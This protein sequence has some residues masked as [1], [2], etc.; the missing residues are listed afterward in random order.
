MI[1]KVLS[2]ANGLHCGSP[3]TPLLRLAPRSLF[4]LYHIFEMLATP[5]FLC[6]AFL[7]LVSGAAVDY[8]GLSKRAIPTPVSASTAR[9]YLTQRTRSSPLS[10]PRLPI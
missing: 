2:L 8:T 5:F 1:Y 3:A 4:R 9:F 7:T 6:G 10:L